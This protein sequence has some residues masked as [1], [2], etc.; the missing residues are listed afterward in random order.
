MRLC[1]LSSDTRTIRI[2]HLCLALRQ[3]LKNVPVG[4]LQALRQR[5]VGTQDV[6]NAADPL[7]LFTLR[8][9]K[10][11]AEP[12]AEKIPAKWRS[13]RSAGI[14]LPATDIQTGAHR[15]LLGKD[16]TLGKAERG[17]GVL[18][19]LIRKHTIC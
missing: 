10:S 14:F 17:L 15:M 1:I 3:S 16:A 11:S 5:S 12:A 18:D 13:I 7:H 19:L 8:N 2:R 4:L 6:I 9:S